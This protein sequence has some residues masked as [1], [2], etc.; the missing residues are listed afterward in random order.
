MFV[1][2]SQLP[3]HVLLA[4]P[5]SRT[6]PSYWTPCGVGAKYEPV[7]LVAEGVEDDLERVHLIQLRVAARVSGHDLRRVAI[8]QH[9]AHVNRVVVVKDADFGV[10]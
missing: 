9:D 2:T 5:W 4:L 1:L 10:L 3:S 7:L 8:A 6:W